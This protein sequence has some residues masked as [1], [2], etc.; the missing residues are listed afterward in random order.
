LLGKYVRDE[1]A[2]NLADAIRRLTSLP[3][4]NLSLRQRGSLKPGYYA[5]VVLFD[6]ATIQDHANYAKPHQLSTGISEVFVNGVQV[7]KDGKHTGAKPGR[8]VRGP[9]WTRWPGGGAC[10]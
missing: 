10:T 4:A 1:K 5:D 3:A 7:L 6:P 2:A 9:G 8:F